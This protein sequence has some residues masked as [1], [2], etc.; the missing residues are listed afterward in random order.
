MQRK[1]NVRG[2]KGLG[3][4]QLVMEEVQ[5][6]K[7]KRTSA[8]TPSNGKRFALNHV[9]AEQRIEYMDTI[10]QKGGRVILTGC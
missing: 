4:R 9:D 6:E 3:K 10:G 8:T 5:G 7:K 1:L 2:N